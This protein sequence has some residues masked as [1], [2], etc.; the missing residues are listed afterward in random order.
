MS[1]PEDNIVPWYLRLSLR[2]LERVK[3]GDRKDEE[4]AEGHMEHERG[5]E[6]GWQRLGWTARGAVKMGRI[7]GKENLPK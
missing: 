4:C 2:P 7:R 6:P 3:V 1:S 5:K